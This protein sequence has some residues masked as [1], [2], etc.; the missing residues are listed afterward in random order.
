[1]PRT[2]SSRTRRTPPR[3][4]D[5]RFVRRPS[6][7]KRA[8]DESARRHATVEH[9][10]VLAAALVCGVLGLAVHLLWIVAIVLMALLFGLLAT[11]LRGGRGGIVS[12]LVSEGKTVVAEISSAAEAD[13]ADAGTSP[14]EEGPAP[15]GG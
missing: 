6:A 9:L 15:A 8:T 7:R 3:A 10:A 1:M 14:P 5:G 11:E 4:A 12:E 13:T 2:Q